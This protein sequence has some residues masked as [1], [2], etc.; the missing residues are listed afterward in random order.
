MLSSSAIGADELPTALCSGVV[1]RNDGGRSSPAAGATSKQ[2]NAKLPFSSSGCSSS[3]QHTVKKNN[4]DDLSFT[5]HDKNNI[6][7]LGFPHRLHKMLSVAEDE[8]NEHIFSWMPNGASFRIHNR[9][10]FANEILPKYSLHRSTKIRS[11]LRQLNLY[12]FKRVNNKT[13][14]YYGA[15]SHKLFIRDDPILCGSITRK[16]NE[17]TTSSTTTMVAHPPRSEEGGDGILGETNS[18]APAGENSAAAPHHDEDQE[19]GVVLQQANN[20]N[21]HDW[22]TLFQ[23]K[24]YLWPPVVS[25]KEG[26][27]ADCGN[28]HDDHHDV[29]QSSRSCLI[30]TNDHPCCED[31]VGQTNDRHGDLLFNERIF[32]MLLSGAMIGGDKTAVHEDNTTTISTTANAGM[33]LV[34]RSASSMLLLDDNTTHY[35]ADH[36]DDIQQERCAGGQQQLEFRAQRIAALLKELE[37]TPVV[38][39]DVQNHNNL[40]KWVESS[41]NEDD[42]RILESGLFLF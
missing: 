11:F 17:R 29:D 16:Y 21:V 19:G 12:G 9:A 34:S 5:L 22:S 14:K 25:H 7:Q 40:A 37:P 15:Y 20:E 30:S 18:N 24:Y 2:H 28:F 42:N 13:S 39:G 41:Y 31:A 36:R 32:D 27:S 23:A 1:F 10:K 8:G 3:P 4:T 6:K 35:C 38:F 26:C 33:T